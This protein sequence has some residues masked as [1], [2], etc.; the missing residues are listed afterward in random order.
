M[1]PRQRLKVKGQPRR[2]LN[3]YNFFFGEQRQKMLEEREALPPSERLPG[4]DMF[5]AMGRA[6]ADR[7]KKL[8]PEEKKKYQLLAKSEK[9]R[10]NVE[11]AEFT[12][13]INEIELQTSKR[14]TSKVPMKTSTKLR[15]PMKLASQS[16]APD[17]WMETVSA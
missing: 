16:Q 9:D 15:G 7:W 14:A 11:M 10:Y 2:P 8:S 13:K 3:A 4:S 1:A 17:L 5:A 6:V 12:K